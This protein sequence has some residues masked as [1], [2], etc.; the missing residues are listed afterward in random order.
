MENQANGLQSSTS[1]NSEK[2]A[3][4]GR[5]SAFEDKKQ[6]GPL[7]GEDTWVPP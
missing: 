4:E 1:H 6:L 5:E 2:M 3:S 7:G